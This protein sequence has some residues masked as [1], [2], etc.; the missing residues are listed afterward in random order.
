MKADSIVINSEKLRNMRGISAIL[1]FL[2]QKSAVN[3]NFFAQRH[4]DR[5]CAGCPA[6]SGPRS[7]DNDVMTR[8]HALPGATKQQI[9]QLSGAKQLIYSVYDE[10]TGAMTVKTVQ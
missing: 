8:F 7:A 2:R 1:P 3:G 6:D 10:K 4:I 5:L 9:R